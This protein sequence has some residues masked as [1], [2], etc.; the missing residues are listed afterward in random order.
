[1]AGALIDPLPVLYHSSSSP[2]YEGAV[3]EWGA[4]AVPFKLEVGA[5]RMR[6]CW[7]AAMRLFPAIQQTFK[8]SRKW[9]FSSAF[10]AAEM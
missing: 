8:R 3:K 10:M 4:E 9:S 6:V 2:L 7:T 1:M 5:R